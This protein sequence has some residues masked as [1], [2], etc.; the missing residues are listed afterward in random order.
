MRRS[1]VLLG[2]A[3]LAMVP[4]AGHAQVASDTIPVAA[5]AYVR[6]QLAGEDA[7]RAGRVLAVTRDS[8]ALRPC[9]GCTPAA[10]ARAELL[11]LEA[12]R[13]VPGTRTRHGLAG[14]GAGTLLAVGATILT[15]RRA[16]ARRP[17][18][19]GP[20]CDIVYLALPLTAAS[21]LFAGALVGAALPA[22]RW[23]PAR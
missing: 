12:R 20:S 5:G 23:R 4:A 6:L 2:S 18:G 1:S 13:G 19:D 17:R 11:R 9:L 8:V 14:A 15:G 7:W 22:E 16:C 10:F 21:G 3:A